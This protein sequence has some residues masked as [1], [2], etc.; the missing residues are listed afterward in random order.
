[1]TPN[2]TN[3]VIAMRIAVFG[4]IG[5]A[6]SAIAAISSVPVAR[7][8]APMAMRNRNDPIRLTTGEDERRRGRPAASARGGQ[9]V[10]EIIASSK[11]T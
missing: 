10:R 6:R 11:K 2:A 8:S 9:R 1:L 7:Y 4:S 3:S 5:A